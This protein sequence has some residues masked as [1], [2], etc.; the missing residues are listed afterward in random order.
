M[1]ATFSPAS[2]KLVC[3]ELLFDTGSVVNQM[4]S[5]VSYED[6]QPNHPFS[7][8]SE[9]DALLDSV[10]P[11]VSQVQSMKQQPCSVSVSSADKGD[12]S[13]DEECLNQQ[14]QL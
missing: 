12:A 2:N 10:L 4:K 8:I 14:Q 13:S 9:T 11:Q 1:R 5:L 7:C 3:A 6:M